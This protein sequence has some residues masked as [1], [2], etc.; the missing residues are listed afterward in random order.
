M[1]LREKNFK[2][3]AI[4][5]FYNPMTRKIYF[6]IPSYKINDL[7]LKHFKNKL[8]QDLLCCLK[9]LELKEKLTHL[10]PLEYFVLKTTKILKH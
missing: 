7:E 3:I 1:I 2:G 9:S 5:Y 10:N 8:D 4:I 6:N